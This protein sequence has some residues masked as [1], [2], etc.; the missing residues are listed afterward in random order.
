[1]VRNAYITSRR[2]RGGL[3][4]YLRK[5]L[6][7]VVKRHDI[8]Y[9]SLTR[10][11]RRRNHVFFPRENALYELL[12]S[13]VREWPKQDMHCHISH[14]LHPK[15]IFDLFASKSPHVQEQMFGPDVPRVWRKRFMKARN[16]QDL[17]RWLTATNREDR[18]LGKAAARDLPIVNLGDFRMAVEHVVRQNFEDGVSQLG[19]RFSPLKKYASVE[20]VLRGVYQSLLEAESWA[21]SAFERSHRVMMILCFNRGKYP[22]Q[23][24]EEVVKQLVA[25]KQRNRGTDFADRLFGVD[26]A[27][28]TEVKT[29]QYRE[30]LRKAKAGNFM[31]SAHVGHWGYRMAKGGV[32]RIEQHLGVVYRTVSEIPELD[33]IAHALPAGPI[34]EDLLGERDSDGN[35]Y[36]AQRMGTITRTL[37]KLWEMLLKRKIIIEACP[38]SNL[39]SNKVLDYRGHPFH[40]WV[41]NGFNVMLGIDGL[42]YWPSTLSEEIVRLLYSNPTRLGASALKKLV[43]PSQG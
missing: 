5:A 29:P 32:R 30:A 34:P 23:L 12:V 6:P 7:R 8:A 40:F 3:R 9:R 36:D 41:E 15:F 42:W 13:A 38:S 28:P 43:L 4:P 27:G 26:I 17:T 39:K 37:E 22:P 11:L 18:F 35:L 10:V 33:S 2:E 1:M 14:S 24:V 19:L 31:C 20:D 21:D 25:I 16:W